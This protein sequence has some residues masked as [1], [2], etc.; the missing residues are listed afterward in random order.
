MFSTSCRAHAV[1]Y[2]GSIDVAA[3]VEPAS[4][5][6]S[7]ALCV[8]DA[9]PCRQTHAPTKPLAKLRLDL[10]SLAPTDNSSR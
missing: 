8:A 4:D 1:G 2:F 9:A 6:A 7:G 10:G 3:I 5:N